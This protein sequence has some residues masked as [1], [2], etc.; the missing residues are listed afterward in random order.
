MSESKRVKAFRLG[1]AKEIPKFPNDKASLQALQAKALGPLL[2]DYANWAI[3]YV[4]PRPRTVV[5]ESSASNDP[6][7]QSRSADIQALLNKVRQGDDLTPYLSLQ[8]HTRG[9]TPAASGTGLN[10]DRWAD[11]DMLLN[12]MGYHHFHFDAVPH[13]QMRSDDVFFAHATR[14]TF[15]VVGIFNHA[16]FESTPAPRDP[17]FCP[18]RA[19]LSRLGLA[20]SDARMTAERNRLWQIFEERATRGAP[21]GSVLVPS[22]IATSGHSI[23]FVKLSADYARVIA[24]IDQALDDPNYVRGLYQQAAVPTPRKPKLRWHLQVLDLGLLDKETGRFFIL[25]KGPN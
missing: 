19:L 10:V 17:R 3:R 14:D 20:R 9:F 24:E 4:A 6:R 5:I 18:V 22:M 13:N 15:T 12:V 23:Y 16:V 21:A 1:L 2:I 7:W 11:K 25:R 8:P